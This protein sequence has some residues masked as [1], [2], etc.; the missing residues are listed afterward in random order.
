MTTGPGFR[1]ARAAVFAA[2]CVLT[3]ALG[4]VLMSEQTLPV[5]AMAHA[6][7]ATTA[8][9]WWLAGRE[10]GALVVTGSAMAAQLALHT[11]FSLS[12]SLT[13][14]TPSTPMVAHGGT[15]GMAGMSGSMATGHSWSPGM[16]LAHG[17]AAL[18]CGLWLWRGEAAA[19]RL[20]RSLAAC[21]F[22]PLRRARRSFAFPG[23]A[24]P[25]RPVVAFGPVRRLRA[26]SLRYAVLRRGPPV[27]PVCG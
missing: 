19:S 2:V 21:V 23:Q 22:A 11:A 13:A 7:A 26:M 9:A 24:S 15:G 27:R 14:P 5:S 17:L 10:R 12:Q 6:F 18:I 25:V 1:L 3:T 20:G 8:G 16:A 4:H